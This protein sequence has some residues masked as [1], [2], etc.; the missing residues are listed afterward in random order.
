M[1][2]RKEATEKK[3]SL[4]IEDLNLDTKPDPNEKSLLEYKKE[5]EEK[6]KTCF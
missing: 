2:K 3:G 4:T 5:L 6:K 1:G